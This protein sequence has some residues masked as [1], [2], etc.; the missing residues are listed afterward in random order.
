[1]NRIIKYNR[2]YTSLK[3]SPTHLATMIQSMRGRPYVI[4]PVAS[5]TITHKE[6]VIRITPPVGKRQGVRSDDR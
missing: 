6:I 1:M 2:S 4:S 5:I 3:K